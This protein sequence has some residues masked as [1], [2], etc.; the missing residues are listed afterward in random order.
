MD[1]PL[2][3]YSGNEKIYN[4]KIFVFIWKEGVIEERMNGRKGVYW[5]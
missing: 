4:I 5:V 3:G 1:S 2:E